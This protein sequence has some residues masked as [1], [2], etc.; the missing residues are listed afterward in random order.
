MA[1]V[2]KWFRSFEHTTPGCLL[3]VSFL[4]LRKVKAAVCALP[5]QYGLQGGQS[6]GTWLSPAFYCLHMIPTI[7]N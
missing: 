5:A 6:K 1:L 7:V 2:D 3:F 4:F